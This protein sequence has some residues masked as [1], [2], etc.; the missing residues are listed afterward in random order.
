[1]RVTADTLALF[2]WP[3]LAVTI[4]GTEL[5]VQ[6]RGIFLRRKAVSAAV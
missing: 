1:M 5:G 3:M 4:V 2:L 6:W